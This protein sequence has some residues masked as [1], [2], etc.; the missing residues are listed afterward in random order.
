MQPDW[1]FSTSDKTGDLIVFTTA[2][3]R[4]HVAFL[5]AVAKSE[6]LH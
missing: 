2:A 1:T 6:W 3:A 4:H 5:R